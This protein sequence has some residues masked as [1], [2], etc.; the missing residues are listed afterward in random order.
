VTQL[1]TVSHLQKGVFFN[2]NIYLL[3]L[4]AIT[5]IVM[6]LNPTRGQLERTLSQR[7]QALYREQLGQRPSQVSC[8]IFDQ[9]VMIILENSL[10][11]AEQLLAENGKADL[12]KQVR[13][14]LD[15]VIRRQLKALIEEILDGSVV[16][17]LS[18]ATLETGRTGIIVVLEEAP[19][20]RDANA[21]QR[22]VRKESDSSD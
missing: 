8:Q 2:W 12:A 16:D 9:K 17:L 7:I 19:Q 3:I 5:L 4:T 1:K 15:E 14:D 6:T 20:V 18:D 13:S 11:A 10:T 21:T 22:G